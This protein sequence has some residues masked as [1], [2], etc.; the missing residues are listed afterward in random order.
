MATAYQGLDVVRVLGEQRICP[1]SR[2]VRTEADWPS[3]KIVSDVCGRNRVTHQEPHR[4]R[5]R[6]KSC[7]VILGGRML[8]EVS[9]GKD[10]L[11]NVLL[12]G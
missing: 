5:A 2:L 11:V 1:L 6:R 8:F 9:V 3:M 7:K 12:G 10:F 4:L